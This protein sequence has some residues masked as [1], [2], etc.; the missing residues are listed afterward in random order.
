VADPCME[1][2]NNEEVEVGVALDEDGVA[3]LG[4]KL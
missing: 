1:A 4:F 2:I 3:S